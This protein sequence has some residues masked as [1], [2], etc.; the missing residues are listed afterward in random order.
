MAA[1]CGHLWVALW[2][3]LIGHIAT[4]ELEEQDWEYL[5]SDVVSLHRLKGLAH[6]FQHQT[7]KV[8]HDHR[9]RTPRDSPGHYENFKAINEWNK[10]TIKYSKTTNHSSL[11]WNSM[12]KAIFADLKNC[13]DIAKCILQKQQIVRFSRFVRLVD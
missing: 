13:L 1:V 2:L 12:A 3:C 4:F 10:G 8:Q 11:E 5:G 9:L 7:V 6:R